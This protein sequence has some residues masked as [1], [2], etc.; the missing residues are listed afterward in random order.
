[1][2]QPLVSVLIRTLWRESL[3]VSLQSVQAQ[4][5]PNLEIVL[6]G[7]V[8]SHLDVGSFLSTRPFK[9][10][11]TEHVAPR[12]LAANLTLDQASG[13][14]CIFLDEDDWWDPCHVTNL[15]K[16]LLTDQEVTREDTS[17]Q[18]HAKGSNSK[19]LHWVAHSWVQLVK[20]RANSSLRAGENES[21]IV[22]DVIGQEV[23]SVRLLAGNCLAI[24][25]ALFPRT[26]ITENGCRFDEAMDLFEDWDFWIQVS[27]WAQFKSVPKVTAF[28]K[29]HESSG[30]HGLESFRSEPALYIYRKWLPRLK[31]EESS[32]LMERLWQHQE[33]NEQ[34]FQLMEELKNTKLESDL[35]DKKS[36]QELHHVS[37]LLEQKQMFLDSILKS[38]SWRFFAF[39]RAIANGLRSTRHFFRIAY[40]LNK[41]IKSKGGVWVLFGRTLKVFRE[42]GLAALMFNIWRALSPSGYQPAAQSHGHD[43]NDYLYWVERFDTM[44][45]LQRAHIRADIASW[46]QG[47]VSERTQLPL[48]SVLMPTYNS[49]LAYLRQAIE[50]VQ[51]QLYPHWELCIADDCS[52][53]LGV[54]ELLRDYTSKDARI[55][56][57]FRS[58]NGHISLASNSA[59]DLV[60]GEWVALFD[61]DDLLTEHALYHVARHIRDSPHAHIIYSDEDKVDANGRR[62]SPHFKGNWNPELFFTQNYLSH[63]GVYRTE[64][65]RKIGGF[66]QGLEGS[67]DH[68]LV[69]RCL[70]HCPKGSIHH[71]AKVLYHW[72]AIEGS[73]ALNASAKS[74]ADEARK[75]ALEDYF[76]GQDLF[77]K[78]SQGLIPNTAR[79]HYPLPSPLP[80]VSLIIPTRDRL[81]LL[82][83][84]V[85]SILD[86]TKYR[87][88]EVI[89]VDNGSKEPETLAFFESIVNADSRVKVIRDDREFNFSA[90]NNL[91]A[92]KAQGDILG[93]INNDIEVISPD[94]LTEM[95]SLSVRAD[96]GCVG[97][98]LYFPNDTLQHGGV[99]LGIKGVANHSHRLFARYDPGYFGRL[100][101][102]Q[103]MS[104]VTGACLILRKGLYWQVGG[105]NEQDLKVAFN[106]IDL[107]LKV[108]HLG[109]RNVWTPH[110]ELYHHESVS[111]GV[112]DTPEKKARFA[113]EVRYMLDRW[114]PELA[115]DPY[116]N[117]NLTLEEEDFSLSWVPR[118]QNKF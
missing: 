58:G 106:D 42:Q 15:M 70:P 55:K 23:D 3:R 39:A 53:D 97:A 2:S 59:L 38:R 68:D 84:C 86:K 35:K 36:A 115:E 1:M 88:F 102:T 87:H 107:C 20:E 4:T 6:V 13:E 93:L 79:I 80:L 24:H 44:D 51:R 72:R 95:V 27:R 99:V 5:Y 9:E 92:S 10:I 114:G 91:A 50:S 111:R 76:L 66:R 63:L 82:S 100:M 104:A 112:E 32:V 31:D 57:Y 94:W 45:E 22:L 18:V 75:K 43:R 61:H 19:P 40:L 16:A 74:Y 67:Q 12:A 69:L 8:P 29:V 98:K 118:V 83:V 110:A 17:L 101:V 73:T 46:A 25:S 54:G 81:D 56:V 11:L 34:I 14:Y 96:V 28:Y 65:L 90:L 26:L 89:I 37:S 116:Y 30:V 103:T 7:P 52:T 41:L 62:F 64:L 60:S 49:P 108:S 78:I 47:D 105:L 113:K 21:E 117:P 33:Q 109:L 48:I 77:V 85:Q 71:I